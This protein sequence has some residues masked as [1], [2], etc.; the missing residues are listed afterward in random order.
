MQ[1]AIR[2]G[3]RNTICSM[4]IMGLGQLMY[5][6]VAKGLTFLA[7]QAAALWYFIS[8]GAQSMYGFFSLGA[9]R[10][11]PSIGLEGDNSIVMMIMGIFAFIMLGLYIA[12]YIR[13]IKDAYATQRRVEGGGRPRKLR[14]ELAHM[15]DGGFY[16][17]AL[18]LPIL[19]VCVFNILPIIFMV[20]IAF[21]DYG[22]DTVP[23]ELVSW[24]GLDNFAR[25][26]NL[27]QFGDTFRRILGWNV[28]WA[29]ASTA[30]NYLC[31]L[32]LA[33][34]LN[35]KCVRGKAFWRMFPILA[36]AVPGFIT[37]LGFRFMF[38]FGGPINQMIAAG[39]G[40]V[41]GF[42]GLDAGWVA[43]GVGLF[44][45]AWIMVPS[46]MLLSTGVLSNMDGTLHEAGRIDGAGSWQRFRSITLP[47]VLFATMPVLI[48]QFVGNFNNFGI[49][50][51]LRG[52]LYMEGYFLA[53]DTDLLINWLYNLSIDNNFYSVAAA[54]SIIIFVLTSLFALAVYMLSPSYRQEE[55]FR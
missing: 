48:A 2:N 1:G 49:F 53:S 6:Q 42:L 7:I 46:C 32:G 3:N 47:F 51:F 15:L 12:C 30:L 36:I 14:A 25:L 35:K 37:L 52:G 19:G 21:T 43:R 41:I 54:I 31:G 4:L 11:E 34:L 26:V 28:L 24:V 45:N 33:M 29:V 22:G 16:K 9:V 27:G 20:L 8:A 5:G 39:G 17:S 38:S 10:A 50:F 23:P 40:R 55:T 18:L 13:N 44:V